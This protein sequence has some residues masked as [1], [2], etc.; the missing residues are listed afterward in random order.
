MKNALVLVSIFLMSGVAFSAELYRSSFTLTADTNQPLCTTGGNRSTL[1]SVCA[2]SPSAGA[3]TIF[4][5]TNTAKTMLVVGTGTFGCV[6][7][8][9]MPVISTNTRSLAYTKTGTAGVN[10]GFNCY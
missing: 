8:L 10:I 5:S 9:N 3:V 6:G 4:V 1:Y 7:D 2:S